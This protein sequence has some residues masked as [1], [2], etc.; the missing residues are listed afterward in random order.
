MMMMMMMMMMMEE[1]DKESKC[2]SSTMVTRSTPPSCSLHN[3]P[4]EE[5]TVAT[6]PVISCTESTL[7]HCTVPVLYTPVPA[8]SRD[9]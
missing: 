4:N 6:K 5:N 1:C 3:S 9:K 2:F 8:A 7:P